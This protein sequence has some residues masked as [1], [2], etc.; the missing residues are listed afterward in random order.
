MADALQILPLSVEKVIHIDTDVVFVNDPVR[1]WRK[2]ELFNDVQTGAMA[3]ARE[4]PGPQFESAAG[5]LR[6]W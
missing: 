2:F 5:I 6:E 4:F 3:R 1:L